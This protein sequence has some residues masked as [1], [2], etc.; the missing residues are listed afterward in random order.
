MSEIGYSIKLWTNAVLYGTIVL[1]MLLKKAF[2]NGFGN[3]FYWKRWDRPACLDDPKH[4]THGFLKLKDVSIHYVASGPEN[5]PLMLFVHGFPEFWYS[6]RHQ[7]K[8]FQKD[9]RVVAIDQRGYSESSKPS[10]KHNY[11]LV[12]LMSDLEQVILALGYKS[13][14]LVAHDWGGIVAWT[15]SSYYPQCVDKMIM[16]NAPPI[17][18]FLSILNANKAQAKKSWYMFFFQLPCLPELWIKNGNYEIFDL[19]FSLGSQGTDSQTRDKLYDENIAPYK[20]TFSQ[21]GALTPPINYY[22]CWFRGK[23]ED[24]CNHDLK[25]KMPILLIWGCKDTYLDIDLPNAL[26]KEVPGIEVRKL[27]ECGHFLQNDSPNDV[28]KAMRE[29]LSKK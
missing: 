4:G 9:Y 8:E 17:P 16:L 19:V 10:G 27:P 1:F 15:F 24:R 21:T 25:Y 23:V 29:W 14:I 20:Y 7:I 12:K 18:L 13:C 11:S 5:K 28:N 2:V 22:R 26:E 6:W 3:V